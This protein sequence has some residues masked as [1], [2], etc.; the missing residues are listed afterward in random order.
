MAESGE[1]ECPAGRILDTVR[2]NTPRQIV[3]AVIDELADGAHDDD[4]V[5]FAVRIRTETAR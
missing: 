1:E 4:T 3:D 2:E 5:A